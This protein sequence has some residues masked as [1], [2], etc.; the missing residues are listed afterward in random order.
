MGSATFDGLPVEL[1][2]LICEHLRTDD[3]LESLRNLAQTS[4]SSHAGAKDSLFHTII[5][6]V[7][8]PSRLARQVSECEALL[9]RHEAWGKVRN[10]SLIQN[11]KR[12]YSLV[13]LVQTPHDFPT[14]QA[15]PKIWSLFERQLPAKLRDDTEWELEQSKIMGA[16]F[17][18]GHDVRDIPSTSSLDYMYQTDHVWTPVVELVR[19]LSGLTDL[20]FQCLSQFPPSLLLVVHEKRIARLHLRT[21]HLRS[22]DNW[23][24]KDP[25]ELALIRSSSLYS[26]WLS[27]AECL[28]PYARPVERCPQ[29]EAVYQ[30]LTT[31]GL[32]PNLRD[33]RKCH[34]PEPVPR[35][36][37]FIF[38]AEQSCENALGKET[39]LLPLRNLQLSRP[40]SSRSDMKRGEPFEKRHVAEWRARI[41]MS[42]L[43]S[44]TL[45]APLRQDA[46]ESL[47]APSF[48]LLTSLSLHLRALREE[49]LEAVDYYK[50][51]RH[52][53][54]TLAQLK[55][56]HLL[57]WNHGVVSLAGH[58]GN[59]SGLP[60]HRLKRLWLAPVSHEYAADGH[61]LGP[62]P[63][64]QQIIELGNRYPAVED[65][66]ISVKRSIGDR[67]EVDRY[68][69]IGGS[70]KMLKRLSL[71]LDASPSRSVIRN[72][73]PSG[74]AFA[75][76]HFQN[77]FGRKLAPGKL[78][79]YYTNGHIMEAMVNAAVDSDL[80]KA[81]F[82]T[83]IQASCASGSTC[84]L[85]TMLLR[86]RGFELFWIPHLLWDGSFWL[87]GSR[88]NLEL[89][90]WGRGLQRTYFLDNRGL[91]GTTIRELDIAFNR[92]R[93]GGIESD[94]LFWKIFAKLWPQAVTVGSDGWATKWKSWPLKTG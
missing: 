3:D 54:S 5:F 35:D 68:R 71:E 51:A 56:L 13:P 57:G 65:L 39:R 20:V 77:S 17:E 33:L 7:S 87:A 36:H 73:P 8:T 19:R 30:M 44:L 62:P 90:R 38:R 31:K 66:S 29:V 82:H 25:H 69:A 79:R 47:S 41:D 37:P 28:E 45:L 67:D 52:F 53:L 40:C 22:L 16:D 10:I 76:S 63:A 43:E 85:K 61:N 88:S 24:V 46:I 92:D 58:D 70:F 72:R 83:I 89:D 50:A 42:A 15:L 26:I 6:Y 59:I 1:K 27:P 81:I 80:A 55:R 14:D 74:P 23:T 94:N 34:Y 48:P 93:V 9:L 49:D 12:R 18:F 11:S 84:Q 32:A 2:T 75:T 91:G 64:K 4:R 21:W 60:N 78:G 86:A